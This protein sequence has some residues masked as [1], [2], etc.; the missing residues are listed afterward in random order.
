M[1]IDC[2]F[3]CIRCVYI[4]CC[5]YY[6]RCVYRLLFLLYK[7][8][9]SIVVFIVSDVFIDCC[10]YCIRCVYQ[11]LLLLYKIILFQNSTCRVYVIYNRYSDKSITFWYFS[12][13]NVI[14]IYI[15]V[16]TPHCAYQLKRINCNTDI[17]HSERSN[18]FIL[19][20]IM[21]R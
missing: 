10:L 20:E 11:L 5:F 17:I 19:V 16:N 9:I 14:P 15:V 7:M 2:C 1:Y 18:V 6:I 4:D 21:N 12:L 8:C 13:F 3:Y